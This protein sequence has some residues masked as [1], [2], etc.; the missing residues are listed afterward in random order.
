MYLIFSQFLQ[1]VDFEEL[2]H[3]VG[4]VGNMCTELFICCLIFLP[5]PGSFVVVFTFIFLM[6]AICVI[7]P[8]FF[9]GLSIL[10][11]F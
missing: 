11:T 5:M 7:S 4:A 9:K 6:M 8:L 3:F 2:V 1:F 10:L